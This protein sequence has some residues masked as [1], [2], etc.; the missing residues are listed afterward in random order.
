MPEIPDEIQEMPPR[1]SPLEVGRDIN[2]E[3]PGTTVYVPS[4]VLGIDTREDFMETYDVNTVIQ[5]LGNLDFDTH[6]PEYYDC[7]DRAFWGVAH[8]RYRFPG[9]PIGV[10]SGHTSQNHPIP[11]QDHAVIVMWQSVGRDNQGKAILKPILYDPLPNL[12]TGYNR[13]VDNFATV[14]SVIGFPVGDNIPPIEGRELVPLNNTAI[15]FDIKRIIYP[16]HTDDEMGIMD[17]LKNG[18]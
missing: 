5:Y 9:L 14:K 13:L 1:T 4:G 16:L 17:Y 15:V 3:M 18:W 2:G 10:V 7:E 8:A 6:I 11:N 12:P